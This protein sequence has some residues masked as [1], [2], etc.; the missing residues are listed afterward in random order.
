MRPDET[1]PFEASPSADALLQA[2]DFLGSGVLT[3]DT[4]LVIQGW[5][6]WLQKVTGRTAA[7]VVGEPLLAVFPTVAGTRGEAAFRRALEGETVVMSQR[8]HQFLLPLPPN[9]AFPAFEWMQQSARIAPILSGGGVGGAVAVIED[10]TERVARENE[11]REAI[12]RAESVSEAKSAFIAGLSH[13]LRTPLSA[14]ISYSDILEGEISGP[15]LDSQKEH[16]RRVRSAA[17][18]LM[19]IINEILTFSRVD[20]GR[21]LIHRETVDLGA[22]AL[23]ALSLVEPQAEQKGLAVRC[24]LPEHAVEA[25]TDPGKLRQILVNLLGNAVKFTDRGQ[26]EL[27]VWSEPEAVYFCVRDT[28]PGIPPEHLERIFEPFTQV[29]PSATGSK[30]GSGL[31]LPVSRRLARLLGGDL[32]V[33]STTGEGSRFTLSLPLAPRENAS[34]AAG[35]PS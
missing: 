4:D 8:F 2:G 30:S 31:G 19:G 24:H 26:V 32:K 34:R 33:E 22:V 21:E 28:G 3:V 5:N 25:E 7:E 35:E 13:E 12:E 27:S 23:A 15:L 6:G 20:A 11:L 29:E 17:W 16:V 9:P 14:I 1:S 18:H 10:V